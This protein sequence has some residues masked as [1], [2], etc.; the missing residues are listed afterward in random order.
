MAD[1]ATTARETERIE[2]DV[3]V[4]GT[5]MGGGMLGYR[6]AQ[7]GRRVLFVEKG[8]STLPGTPRTIR[9]AM[10]ELAEPAAARSTAT[11]FDALARG[12]RSTDEVEDISGRRAKRFVPFI[13]SGTGGSSALYGMVCERFFARD[14]TPRQNFADPGDSTVPEA[15]P[16]SYEQMRPWYADAEKLLGV[17]GQPDPLRPEAADVN[18]PAAPPFSADNQ[19]IVDYLTGRGLHPYHLPMACDYTPDCATCQ[20]FLCSK[21]CKNDSA[22]NGV[23]PAIT[24]YGAQLLT[25]CRVV[26][27]EADRSQV[28][29][30]ICEHPD[31]RLALRAK[32]VVLAA[33]ALATPVLL[34]NSRSGEWPRG[35]AN[36]SDMVGRNL[37]RHLLDPIEIWP[38]SDSAITAANKEIGLNDFYFYQG[39]KYGTVQSFGSIPPME[40]L[41]NRPGAQGRALRLMTPAVRRVYEKFFTGGLILAAMM[42]DLP[43]RDNRVLLSERPGSD[44]RQRM[45]IQ[46]RLHTGE[47]ERHAAFLRLFKEILKP[48]RTR[49]LGSGKENSNMGHVCGTCRFGTDPATSVLDAH[50]RAHEVDNLYVV[51]TSFFPSSAGL[52]PSLTVAANALRVAA[53]LNESIFAG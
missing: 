31:G 26:H 24:E 29:R 37:M 32:V 7:A 44:G 23:L 13:G 3:I 43:Y 46:Y 30:V 9:S 11:Y 25:E 47:L 6:L 20:T 39:Q 17:R 51:D 16:V 49:T 36:G 40:W 4:V 53:H 21:S 1:G 42:E 50:N 41:I 2:W 22:R 19:P 12:G 35:L 14:F 34:L 52:N 38:Q 28:R 48:F 18:L 15:W 10:P 27:L 33:G 45:R 8:R 5:G